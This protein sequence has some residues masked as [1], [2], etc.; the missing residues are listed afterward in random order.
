MQTITSA[1]TSL[2]QIPALHK[3]SILDMYVGAAKA[4]QANGGDFAFIVDYGAGRY[5][6]GESFLM[7]R[8]N[9]PV[10]SYDPYN[11]PREENKFT[12]EIMKAG[13]CPIVICANVLNVINDDDAIR[14][15]LSNIRRAIR[16]VNGVALFTVYEGNKS[17]IDTITKAGYQ[18]NAR[19]S[20][21]IPILRESFHSVERKGKILIARNAF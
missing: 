10:F 19:T 14:E 2:N 13:Y 17:G 6:A 18:R 12:A 21:Y 5:N 16:N 8:H 9:I 3:S 4:K 20:E 15:I 1:K 7:N 11:R